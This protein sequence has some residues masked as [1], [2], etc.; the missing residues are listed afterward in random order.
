ML[1]DAVLCAWGQIITWL[2]RY[3]DAARLGTV[4]EL[5]MASPLCRQEPSVLLEEAKNLGNFHGAS[6]HGGGKEPEGSQRTECRGASF[7]EA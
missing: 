4:L 3:C 2:A 1:E 5:A 6:I 7:C